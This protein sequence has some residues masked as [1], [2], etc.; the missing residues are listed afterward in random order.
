MSSPRFLPSYNTTL[1]SVSS[2]RLAIFTVGRSAEPVKVGLLSVTS[3]LLARAF[4]L[5]STTLKGS[6]MNLAAA[7]AYFKFDLPVVS[8]IFTSF[9]AVLRTVTV[10][11]PPSNVK[12]ASLP[13]LP[14]LE[15]TSEATSVILPSTG[16]LLMIRIS[17]S[18]ISAC[19]MA[20]STVTGKGSTKAV[21]VS[22][23]TKF[24]F[25]I[26]K[27][28]VAVFSVF[29][30]FGCPA[31]TLLANLILF[32]LLSKSAFVRTMG[33]ILSDVVSVNSSMSSFCS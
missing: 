23:F 1:K 11:F 26:V 30:S 32:S 31:F 24:G 10:V 8:S 3:A 5:F 2:V 16:F 4:T 13:N 6:V 20:N 21:S 25:V 33:C 9:L 19:S 14:N 29:P 18:S 15:T 28:A 27:V 17:A 22:S 12:S 7:S